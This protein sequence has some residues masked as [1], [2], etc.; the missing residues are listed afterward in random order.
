MNAVRKAL[1]S[2]YGSGGRFHGP[3][4]LIEST[5]HASA[6]S[7]IPSGAIPVSSE[8]LTLNESDRRCLSIRDIGA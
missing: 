3:A 4:V 1:K 6:G 7:G 8:R 5:S 2:D